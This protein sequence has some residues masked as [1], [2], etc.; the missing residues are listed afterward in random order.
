MPLRLVADVER[1]KFD[2]RG[3]EHSHPVQLLEDAMNNS[4][5]TGP[6]PTRENVPTGSYRT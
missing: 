6:I 2:M 5:R 4:S 3:I 1:R